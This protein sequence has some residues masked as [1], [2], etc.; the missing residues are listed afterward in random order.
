M[1]RR[2]GHAVERA[3]VPRR[4]DVAPGVGVAPDAV[5]DP[6]D[7]VDGLTVRG[8]PAPPL[9]AVDRTQ[10]PPF[11][12]PLVP[13]GDAVGVEV[14]DVGRALEKPQ[15]LVDDRAHVNRLRGHH[16]EARPEV[17]PHLAAEDAQR[18]GAG[19]IALAHPVLADVA[20]QVEI[21]LHWGLLSG[22]RGVMRA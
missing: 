12:R 2:E 16:R 4:H 1:A 3:D 21:L 17:E 15:E 10:L 13:D 7:L 22:D 19:A 11:V 6:G 8:L 20:H 5:H 9:R 14:A 18:A